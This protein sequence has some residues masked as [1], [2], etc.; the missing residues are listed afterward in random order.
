MIVDTSALIA[1]AARE[2]GADQLLAALQDGGVVPAPVLLEFMR[3]ATRG[4]ARGAPAAEAFLRDMLRHELRVEPFTVG[5]AELSI[6]ANRDHGRG[7]GR[8][9]TL[10][11][12]DLMVYAVAK[13]LNLPILCTGGD[14]AVTGIAIHAASRPY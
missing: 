11:L 10:N 1:I 2:D 7:N 4:G 6:R 8:G 12:L 14:Y 9:G 3:V 5:D 13:R